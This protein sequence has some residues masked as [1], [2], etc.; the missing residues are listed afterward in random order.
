[1]EDLDLLSLPPEILA[2]IFSN[3]PWNQL[4]NVKLTSRKFNYVTEKYLKDMQKPKIS[5]IHFHNV[6]SYIDEIDRL[7]VTYEILRTDANSCGNIN[8]FMNTKFD[9][10]PSEIDQLHSFLK[11]VDLTSLNLVDINLD[12]HTEAIRIFN[13]YFHNTNKIDDIYFVV[14]DSDKNFDDIL[15]FLQKIQNVGL[16]YLHLPLPHQNVPRDFIIPVRNSLEIL[17]IY[18]RDDTAF[19]NPRII[20]YIVENNPDLRLY[21][22]SFDNFK[23][24]KMVIGTILKGVLSKRNNSCLH[25]CITLSFDLFKF[26]ETS[27]LLS[28]LYSEEFPYNATNNMRKENILYTGELRC[29]VCGKFDSI[30]IFDNEY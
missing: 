11:K 3:I 1:M 22:L 5:E 14:R 24:Y 16:L 30:E 29:P 18:E 26:E 4:I 15:S 21:I 28:Y 13:G 7:E 20:K 12:N 23:T 6:Y 25:N 8:R 10:L 2:K 27:E 17:D 9:L 19:F